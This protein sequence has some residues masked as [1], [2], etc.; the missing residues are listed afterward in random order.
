M[1]TAKRT[2][3]AAKKS[4]AK[5]SPAKEPTSPGT[6]PV[7]GDEG[8]PEGGPQFALSALAAELGAPDP[9]LIAALLQDTP[10]SELVERGTRI[11]SAK[12]VTDGVRMFGI[13]WT[14]YKGATAAQKQR[15]RGCSREL[16]A[17][18]VAEILRLEQLVDQQQAQRQ[19][20]GSVREVSATA[21]STAWDT[22]LA[23]RGQAE[24][25][26]RGAA[27]SREAR[28]AVSEAV[29]T[30]ETSAALARGLAALAKLLED[31]LTAKD[32]ALKLRLELFT[33]DAG[34]AKE[35]Q[36]ASETLRQTDANVKNRPQNARV[37]Q[38]QLDR[39][40]GLCLLLLDRVMRAFERGHDLDPTIP[41]LLP[42]A[43]RSLL[44]PRPRS[45][46]KGEPTDPAPTPA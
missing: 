6:P 41:R 28:T 30:A 16:L 46:P 5:K 40:D 44:S 21:Q 11:A 3:P 37:S 43:T 17:L 39:Q 10:D 2:A 1:P 35:L 23:L 25:A 27:G 20:E 19:H 8:T 18:G 31:W 7:P 22:A 29:G 32:P 9:A 26:L 13:G 12:V 34:Y 42:L 33:L 15:L 38:A 4:P 45:A 24:D 36:R 14:F